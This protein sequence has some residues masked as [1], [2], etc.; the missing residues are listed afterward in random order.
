MNVRR[1]NTYNALCNTEEKAIQLLGATLVRLEKIAPVL[2]G[3]SC[4]GIVWRGR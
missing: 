2:H 3:F 1:F 4:L